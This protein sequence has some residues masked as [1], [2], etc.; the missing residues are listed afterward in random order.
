M[1]EKQKIG[2]IEG[3]LVY[4]KIAEADKKYKSEDTEYSIGVIIGDEDEAD[5]WDEKFAKQP[6]KKI[7]VSQ[8]E[9]KFKFALPEEFEGLKNVYQITL[10]RAAVVDGVEK[11]PQYRPKVFLETDDERVDI[12]ESR[13]IANGSRGKVSYRV[14]ENE[15]YGNIARLNNV[16]IKEEDFIEY[17]STSKEAGSEFG[18]SK[19]VKKEPANKAATEARKS[20]KEAEEEKEESTDE[21]GDSKP[22]K[23]SKPASKKAAVKPK[24]EEPEDL[25]DAPY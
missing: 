4:A 11:F 14:S 10:K 16:L 2:F 5:A 8:F 25:D 17:Q 13:L 20:K 15:Q 3:V 7:K 12:T 19:P 21:F 18:D 9:E 23:T 22:A 1:T 24:E 6:A